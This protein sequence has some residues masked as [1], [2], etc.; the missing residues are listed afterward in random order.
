MKTI[1]NLLTGYA[2]NAE[3]CVSYVPHNSAKYVEFTCL[4]PSIG[5]LMF[6]WEKT[7][8]NNVGY[9]V[10]E[11]ISSDSLLASVLP[12][13]V[14]CIYLMAI[15]AGRR[16][17]RDR[18][19]WQWKKQLAVWNL[20]LSLFSFMGMIRMLPPLIHNMNTLSLRENMCGDPYGSFIAGS[21]GTWVQF[22]ILSK[23]PE[24]IDTFF[25][26]IHK[27]PLIFLHWYHHIT[28]LLYVWHGSYAVMN[29]VSPVFGAM[30]YTVHAMMYGYYFLMAIKKKPNWMNPMLITT[31]QIMQMVAGIVATSVGVYYYVEN[32]F[33]MQEGKENSCTIRAQSL[34]AA[35]LMYGSYLVLFMQFFAK[36][37]MKPTDF[38]RPQKKL[39]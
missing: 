20:C 5:R 39:V 6:N 11:F 38:I 28:V 18:A 29:P 27:K 13:I 15:F 8:F 26:V 14:V 17:M 23:F 3:E 21:T 30:N 12:S 1:L 9:K 10:F 7:Y 37:F 34:V 2:R 25:I 4:Y 22:F 31:A 19:A 32:Q 35:I 36:R 16:Y 24:L 33:A